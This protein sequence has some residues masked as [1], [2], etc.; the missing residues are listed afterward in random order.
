MCIGVYVICN[1]LVCVCERER[2]EREYVCI[3]V[4]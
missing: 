1:I 3:G 2:E 4:C